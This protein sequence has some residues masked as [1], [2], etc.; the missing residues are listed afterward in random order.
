MKTYTA[1]IALVFALSAVHAEWE[2]PADSAPSSEDSNSTSW[3]E[4]YLPFPCEDEVDSYLGCISVECEDCLFDLSDDYYSTP[5][6]NLTS[7][8]FCTEFAACENGNCT[9]A[10]CETEE[11]VMRA[12]WAKNA[13]APSE[14]FLCW[15]VCDAAPE[16]FAVA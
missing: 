15:G 11:A 8:E 9:A 14:K 5:C 4:D 6:A 3:S 12:C 13:T 7:T 16:L 10:S 1:A 2:D